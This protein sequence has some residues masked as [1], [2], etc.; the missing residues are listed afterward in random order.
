MDGE[1]TL[2]SLPPSAGDRLV[3]P[4]VRLSASRRVQV[5]AGT[6][7]TSGRCSVKRE[8]A[9]TR[10]YSAWG[11]AGVRGAPGSLRAALLLLGEMTTYFARRGRDAR[12]THQ[13]RILDSGLPLLLKDECN[14]V[15]SDAESHEMYTS[16]PLPIAT[17]FVLLF[18]SLALS[19]ATRMA[20][21]SFLLYMGQGYAERTLV[22]ANQIKRKL[23]LMIGV[24]HGIDR[25]MVFIMR[26]AVGQANHKQVSFAIYFRS[27]F[28][29]TNRSLKPAPWKNLK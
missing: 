24:S 15:A 8:P 2:T 27:F 19:L 28:L 7:P 12:A 23:T 11:S 17:G 6:W 16:S 20:E 9:V 5:R 29:K 4:H 10:G 26:V 3:E 13:T 1:P 22:C 14:T 25:W 18:F 21:S